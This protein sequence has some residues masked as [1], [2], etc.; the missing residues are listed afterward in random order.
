MKNS[1]NRIVALTCLSLVG[2]IDVALSDPPPLESRKWNQDVIYFVMTDR[3]LD[4]DTSNNQPVGSDGALYD[5]TQSITTKYHGGDLR[6]LELAIQSGYFNKL[7]ITAI[8]ITPPVRNGWNSSFDLDGPK[9]GYHGYWAR[10]FLD[11]DPHLV[12]RT[13][14]SGTAYSDDRDGRMQHYKDFIDLAH[15]HNIKIVQDIVCN[16]IG[17]HFYYDVNE[18]EVFDAQEGYEWIQPYKSSGFYKN[19]KWSDEPQWNL[20]V[21][22]I[23]GPVTI[24]GKTVPV[25][26]IFRDLD[27]FGR[28][29]F[30]SDSLGASDGEEIT[31]DFFSLRDIWTDKSS[32]NFDKLVDEFVETYAFY[33]DV[34]GIDGFRVDTVK[35]VHHDF[36]DAFTQRLRER[37][38]DKANRLLI[39]GEVYDG[40]PTVLGSYTYRK[41][42]ATNP[43]PCFDA[44][45]NFQTC[46][47]VRDYLRTKG[48]PY[49]PARG[50]NRVIDALNTTGSKS[51]FNEQLGLDGLSSRQKMVNFVEN[52][53]GLNRFMVDGVDFAAQQL[54][55]AINM[56]ME[57]IP[58]LYYGSEL[59]MIDE[60]G[61]IGRDSETGRMTF[62]MQGDVTRLNA[63]MG[64]SCFKLTSF[65]ANLRNEQ[66]SLTSGRVGALWI[67]ADSITTDDGIFAMARYLE[68]DDR[69]AI[70]AI[71]NAHPTQSSSTS[72]TS[73]MKLVTHD[74]K[75]LVKSTQSLVAIDVPGFE[76]ATASAIAWQNGIPS[77]TITVPPR[78]F[79]LFRVE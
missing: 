13:S 18:N 54:A 63:A 62:C 28:K 55:V 8:W 6:G 48:S 9:T 45:L 20:G 25:K 71:F 74:G 68:G 5:S 23:D 12:S 65:L 24:L 76:N 49:G 53:D 72:D 52:H 58:C 61:R 38:G 69:K 2:L 22:P 19:A 40:N 56:L 17:P 46:F 67:D 50:L 3:F 79:A 33:V 70:I 44:L 1:I 14:L 36:W 15:Q 66:P 27:T 39:F 34:L 73:S 64:S 30:S 59:P 21:S 11:I 37:L 35:H 16:H 77:A 57:G 41:D 26:G 47:C 51:L 78:S 7:G 4:G 10:D 32:T 29:G 43:S 31:C 75:P 60:N 42:R